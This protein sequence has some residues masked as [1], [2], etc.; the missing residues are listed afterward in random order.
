MSKKCTYVS[1][2]LIPFLIVVLALPCVGQ[3]AYLLEE[4]KAEHHV[5]TQGGYFPRLLARSN[6]DLLATFKYGSTHA[7]K[8]GKAGLAKSEYG[9]HTW[10][11]PQ[12]V[13]EI[14]DSG[15]AV[16]TTGQLPDGTIFL[17]LVRQTRPGKIFIRQG[18]KSEPYLLKSSDGDQT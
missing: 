2:D 3:E 1:K 4:L 15:S 18:L 14:P 9:R 12:T 13:F 11:V 8:G 16:V 10:S 6:D 5:V 7:E 17:G